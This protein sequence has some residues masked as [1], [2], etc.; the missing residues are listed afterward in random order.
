MEYVRS[1]HS[2]CRI[3]ILALLLTLVAMPCVH[4]QIPSPNE[5]PGSA[6]PGRIDA[7]PD[8]QRPLRQP[9]TIAPEKQ[10]VPL[11]PQGMESIRFVFKS[12]SVEGMT[13][14][15]DAD[16]RPLYNRYIGAEITVAVLFEILAALQKKYLDDG[17]AL[18]KVVIPN[19]DIQ[20]GNV[21]FQAIEGYVGQIERD[22][23][24]P[25]NATIDDAVSR[26][27]AMRPLNTR[28]LERILLLLN[29]L[30]DLN[31]SAVLARPTTPQPAGA[32][33]LV[34]QNTTKPFTYA[35]LSVDNHGSKFAGPWQNVATGYMPHFLSKYGL[36]RASISAT[37]TVKEQQYVS[38]GYTM[39]IFG[40][41]G[42]NISIN[43]V[44]AHAE[45]GSNLD[46][47]DIIGRS[48][49]LSVS[50]SHP[51]IRQREKTWTV[52]AGFEYK[53]SKTDILDDVLYN[54]KLRSVKVGT[55]YSFSDAWRGYNAFDLH[56]VQGLDILGV[57]D[58]GSINLSRLDGDPDFQK[59]EFYAGRL[60]ALPKNFEFYGLVTGQY[61]FDPLLSSEEYGFGGAQKGR[62]YDPSEITGD[63]GVG[64]TLEL[65]YKKQM[66]R[67]GLDMMLQ[68]YVFYDFGKV[69]NID[70][71]A[72]NKISAASA[73]GG[74]RLDV[75]NSWNVDIG[76]AAPLTK[77]AENPP[78]YSTGNGPK[79][80][81]SL[82]KSF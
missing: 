76:I 44:R 22:P 47:L 53:N 40:I 28:T 5:L 68:P 25:S 16:I 10:V 67:L 33:R 58:S 54:D 55:T 37:T 23:T 30:P 2:F 70:R 79:A 72:K 18:T 62:G 52:D 48:D 66:Q 65:R 4:A 69:W 45:P 6:D 60:Q 27:M 17:Y 71:G 15:S 63:S 78:K 34:L 11:I 31:V 50:L 8:F 26:I 77:S 24:L 51:L 74:V 7:M 80:L 39:P 64:I 3:L 61:S 49:T 29:D 36:L 73:G 35:G 56:Y 13:A 43:A 20:G 41:S 82:T 14:Y 1:A 59:F 21:R 42:T 9:E 32:V 12:L 19:Q 46:A 38:L 81:F 75:N 57:R